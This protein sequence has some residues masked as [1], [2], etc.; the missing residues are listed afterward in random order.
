MALLG[1]ILLLI[2]VLSNL[3]T[4]YLFNYTHTH[5]SI[6]TLRITNQ[7][8]SVTIFIFL[9]RC[10]GKAPN[11]GI[12][13]PRQETYG[14]YLYHTF[15]IF[16]V[17]P[18]LESWITRQFH[19]GFFSYNIYKI[20][21]ITLVNFVFCYFASTALVKLLLRLKLGYLPQH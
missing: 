3:E 16:F 21:L 4:W 2:F 17:I 15:F 10:C 8:Y 6:N 5:D 1:G 9:I 20:I 14:I 7:L 11:F 18:V 13:N 12:F 19:I